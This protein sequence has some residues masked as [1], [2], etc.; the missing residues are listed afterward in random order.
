[1]PKVRE[2][3][4]LAKE[5]ASRG[6]EMVSLAITLGPESEAAWAYKTNLVLELAKLAEMSGDAQQ[7]S[8]LSRQY[9]EALKETKRLSN[10]PTSKP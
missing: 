2:T 9:D 7:K 4:E 5:C 6:L 3:F 1:M 10:R 8:E